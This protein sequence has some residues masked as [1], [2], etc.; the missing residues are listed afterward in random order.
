MS[1]FKGLQHFPIGPVIL[2]TFP[3][4]ERLEVSGFSNSSFDGVSINT[5]GAS[6]WEAKFAPIQMTPG[7][8]MTATYNIRDNA[9]RN[10]TVAQTAISIDPVTGNG[11]LSVNSK[12]ICKNFRLVGTLNGKE[13][14]SRDYVKPED[15]S[16]NWLAV[17]AFIVSAVVAAYNAFD[18]KKVVERDGAGNVTKTTTTTSFGG[19]GMVVPGDGTGHG[20]EGQQ[21]QVDHLYIVSTADFGTEGEP[22]DLQGD[23]SH[24]QLTGYGMPRLTLLDETYTVQG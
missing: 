22:N 24:V 20:Y 13:V 23:I 21:Y 19:A 7:T 12:L 6:E 3:D 17:A 5:N 2:T 4:P 16:C 10:K 8:G 11:I 9:G 15:T 14:F 18:Y 1:Q